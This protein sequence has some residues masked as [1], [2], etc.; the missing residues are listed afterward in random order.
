MSTAK[1]IGPIRK[2][3]YQWKAIR[4][5]W[6]KRY[7]VGLDL[8]GNTYWE[9]R[10]HR[11]DPSLP[12]SRFRRIVQYPRSTHYSEIKV[13]PQWH[14][15]LRYQRRE[16]PTLDEQAH[17]LVRREQMKVLAAAADARWEAKPSYLDAPGK[18]KGQPVPPFD[19]S[20]NQ[21]QEQAARKSTATNGQDDEVAQKD[22][23]WKRAARSTGPG[24]TWQPEAWTPTSTRKR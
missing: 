6:R 8:Q 1:P 12:D 22:D 5:P 16:P 2:A 23:P 9:F 15:W 14:Q 13:S 20:R 21:P 4:F 3:W 19:T 7:L 11:G 17:D 18:E 10:L 24:E